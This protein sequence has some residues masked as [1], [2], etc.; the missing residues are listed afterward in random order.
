MNEL[1]RKGIEMPEQTVE[2]KIDKLVDEGSC[3][4][5]MKVTR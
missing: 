2:S 3:N 1:A 4:E 5:V